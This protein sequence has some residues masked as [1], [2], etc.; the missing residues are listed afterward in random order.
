MTK[1]SNFN[2]RLVLVLIISYVNCLENN[3][4][5]DK[6]TTPAETT[7]AIDNFDDGLTIGIMR[8]L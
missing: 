3:I 2:N 6:Y 8:I 7:S 4:T 5:I 1:K